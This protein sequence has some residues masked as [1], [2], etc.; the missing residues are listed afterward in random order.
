MNIHQCVIACYTNRQ[1]GLTN[2]G[3]Q[4]VS[5]KGIPVVHP[6]LMPAT[7]YA[8]LRTAAVGFFFMDGKRGNTIRG[9][10][11]PTNIVSPN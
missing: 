7:T 4:G 8:H 11:W 9:T 3:P 1:P 6:W 5:V 10:H 2:D